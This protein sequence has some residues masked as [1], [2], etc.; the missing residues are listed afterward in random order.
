VRRCDDSGRTRPGG[1]RAARRRRQRPLRRKQ[2]TRSGGT[3]NCSWRIWR[4]PGAS[5][6]RSSRRRRS[7][8]GAASRKE[9]RWSEGGGYSA[10]NS[11]G[12]AA[13]VCRPCFSGTRAWA[14]KAQ[15]ASRG[16]PRFAKASAKRTNPV[17]SAFPIRPRRPAKH[18]HHGKV[19]Y[20]RHRSPWGITLRLFFAHYSSRQ[21]FSLSTE[22]RHR[23]A[24]L[25][26]D[27]VHRGNSFSAHSSLQPRFALTYWIFLMPAIPL[28]EY[29]R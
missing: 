13:Q 14:E 12:A 19:D 23:R 16:T 24:L 27:P 9:R 17:L 2:R 5:R 4:W 6:P 25:I 22:S 11:E 1:S 10:A 29:R 15:P 21:A 28:P 26:A 20:R 3:T 7:G 18:R 8:Y